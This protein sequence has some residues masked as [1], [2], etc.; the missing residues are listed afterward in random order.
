[1]AHFIC[2][3]QQIAKAIVVLVH[4]LFTVWT[5]RWQAKMQGKAHEGKHMMTKF[6]IKK[7]LIDEY[8]NFFHGKWW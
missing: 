6:S 7:K 1:M 2:F 8:L 5:K 4:F 3:G